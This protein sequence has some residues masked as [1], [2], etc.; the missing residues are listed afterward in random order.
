MDG[1]AHNQMP[2]IANPLAY[3]NGVTAEEY[4]DSLPALGMQQ[5]QY[6]STHPSYST[7]NYN[8]YGI[9]NF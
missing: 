1:Y 4:M 6:Q 2:Y 3:T 5:Q 8:G 9:V 7:S